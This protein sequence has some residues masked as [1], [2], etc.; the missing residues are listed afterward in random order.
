MLQIIGYIAFIIITVASCVGAAV[1]GTIT[2]SKQNDFM[3]D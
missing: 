1:A 2:G 3:E